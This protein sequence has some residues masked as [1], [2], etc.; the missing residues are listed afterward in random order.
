MNE[1][2]EPTEYERWKQEDRQFGIRF[3][4]QVAGFMMLLAVLLFVGG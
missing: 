2:K 1:S 3:S 4:F